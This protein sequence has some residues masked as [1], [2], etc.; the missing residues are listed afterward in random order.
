MNSITFDMD[1]LTISG[2]WV[3]PKTGHRFEVRDCYWEDG[4]YKVQ[5]K[6]GQVLDFAAL[7]NYVQENLQP[8]E[9]PME[10]SSNN[11]NNVLDGNIPSE[12]LSELLPDN[13]S[14]INENTLNSISPDEESLIYGSKS[15]EN[16]LVN[17]HYHQN[18]IGTQKSA[19]YDIIDK[20]L[21]KHLNSLKFE[22]LIKDNR[23]VNSKKGAKFEDATSMLLHHFD[24]IKKEEVID[25]IVD[26]S[27]SKIKQSLK[28]IIK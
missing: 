4:I 14:N 3:N 17:N 13:N 9:K 16:S 19:N 21:S 5:T 25:Y 27:L 22:L 28:K 12:V 18:F 11:S 26:N 23:K 2:A 7:E 20:A 6:A 24:D 10:I 15:L 8:G 1:N